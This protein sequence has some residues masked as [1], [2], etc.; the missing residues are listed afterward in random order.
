MNEPAKQF[1]VFSYGSNLCLE[2]MSARVAS[3]VPVARGYVNGYQLRFHKKSIDGSGKADA[4]AT[5]CRS[6]RVWGAIYCIA[7]REKPI[8]DRCEFLGVGYDLTDVNVVTQSGIQP[9]AMYIARP[10]AIGKQMKPYS[11]YLQ[12]VIVGALQHRLP[13]CYVSELQRTECLMDPDSDR[14]NH[15]RRIVTAANSA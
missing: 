2:R 7:L 3:S 9:A 11:W 14:H 8:L 1:H 12:F 4:C 10:D 13:F 5:S 6:D 15:N